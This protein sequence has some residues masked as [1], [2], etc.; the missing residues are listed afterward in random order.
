[1]IL[2]VET[3][4]MM[5]DSDFSD[6]GF[7][8]GARVR[9]RAL[10]RSMRAP[11]AASAA[12]LLPSRA[13]PPHTNPAVRN[14]CVVCLDENASRC[15]LLPCRHQ[16]VCAACGDTQTDCPICLVRIERVL[17]VFQP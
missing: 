1:M 12:M 15:V 10:A 5:E 11:T 2:D 7:P 16:C 3:V 13:D 9:L 17:E 8:V 4:D 14:E 6:I